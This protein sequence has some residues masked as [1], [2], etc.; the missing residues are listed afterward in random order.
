M[1]PIHLEFKV[2]EN[3]A[4]LKESVVTNLY[5]IDN[6]YFPTPWDLNSWSSF[7][8]DSGKV[9]F[10]LTNSDEIIGFSMFQFSDI[11]RFAHLLKILIIPSYR[12]QSLGSFLLSKSLVSLRE[13]GVA[14]FYLEVEQGNQSAL[15]LY[16]KSGFNIIHSKKDFYGENRSAYIMTNLNQ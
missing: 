7:L 14:N 9:L 1:K 15:K 4:N 12:E 16:E 3:N 11:D 10:V 5:K 8:S 13:K 6:A 2:F